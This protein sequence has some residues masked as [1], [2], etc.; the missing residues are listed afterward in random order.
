MPAVVHSMVQDVPE[1]RIIQFVLGGNR[2]V[3][4]RA[5]SDQSP[6]G[7]GAPFRDSQ[8]ALNNP[9]LGVQNGNPY[10]ILMENPDG[11]P[12]ATFKYGIDTNIGVVLWRSGRNSNDVVCIVGTGGPFR[13]DIPGP[14]ATS[15]TPDF[16]NVNPLAGIDYS[17]YTFN[18]TG[19][20]RKDGRDWINLNLVD[21][22]S[23]SLPI[24]NAPVICGVGLKTIDQIDYLYM[25][26]LYESPTTKDEFV[27][28]V[29]RINS[30]VINQ[31]TMMYDPE[32]FS[33]AQNTG[34]NMAVL[35]AQWVKFNSDCT[36][37]CFIGMT[38]QPSGVDPLPALPAGQNFQAYGSVGKANITGTTLDTITLHRKGYARRT[39]HTLLSTDTEID[40]PIACDYNDSD[41]I[42]YVSIGGTRAQVFEITEVLGPGDPL[43]PEGDVSLGV[44]SDIGSTVLKWSSGEALTLRDQIFTGPDVGS[45]SNFDTDQ[46]FHIQWLEVISGYWS[47]AYENRVRTEELINLVDRQVTISYTGGYRVGKKN[48]I[49]S[50]FN[51]L[52]T[53]L[54]S[55]QLG[56]GAIQDPVFID[57]SA[58]QSRTDNFFTT[59]ENTMDGVRLL[60]RV[61]VFG[62]LT[63]TGY[64]MQGSPHNVVDIPEE[65]FVVDMEV[66]R[67]EEWVDTFVSTGISPNDT[68]LVNNQ[69]DLYDD[70]DHVTGRLQALGLENYWTDGDIQLAVG[71]GVVSDTGRHVD[72]L[73]MA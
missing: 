71:L 15:Y 20:L 42:E 16:A 52:E 69:G 29:A 11:A 22:V 49:L 67:P 57:P 45:T 24:S 2:G 21:W 6:N 51:T 34:P 28:G 54:L 1:G 32:I 59:M 18:I 26:Y 27:F 55:F 70:E 19:Q 65:S 37:L 62:V 36:E 3:I 9:P 41:Q 66:I 14:V 56:P 25:A 47:G 33:G 17:M 31:S 35:A 23:S 60:T 8:G 10:Q 7:Y 39:F 61:S 53:R 63:P 72:V 12:P 13:G 48:S 38:P 73:G 58:F 50:T 68:P 44:V 5:I 40:I 30:S 64:R 4:L 46:L 43:G